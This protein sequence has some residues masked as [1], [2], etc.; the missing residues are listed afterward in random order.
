VTL[1]E[2]NMDLSKNELNLLNRIKDASKW[3]SVWWEL[4]YIVPSSLL[5]LLGTLNE[6]KR[7]TIIGLVTYLVF[8]SRMIIHQFRSVPVLKG[9]CEKM[10]R[11]LNNS[12]GTV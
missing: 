2:V 8:H 12:K 10:E 9:L 3:D 6:S 4:S 7:T 1:K 11:H 5:V